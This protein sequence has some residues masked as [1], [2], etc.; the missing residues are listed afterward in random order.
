MA[1]RLVRDLFPPR[2]GTLYLGARPGRT[3][4]EGE[5]SRCT[6]KNPDQPAM[7]DRFVLV[8]PANRRRLFA[9][10]DDR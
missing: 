7:T 9:G 1:V 2:G 6:S 3:D 10:A 5:T 8:R 4:F